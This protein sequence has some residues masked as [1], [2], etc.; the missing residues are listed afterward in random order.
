MAMNE[1]YPSLKSI[2]VVSDFIAIVDETENV[3]LAQRVFYD[4]AV[5][6]YNSAIKGFP[7]NVFAGMFGFVE[8]K[9][10]E[11]GH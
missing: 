4:D 9:Y 2:Q 5:A 11:R 8:A 1:N 7:G 6:S 3:I 10:Y